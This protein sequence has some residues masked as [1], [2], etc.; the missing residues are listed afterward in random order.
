MAKNRRM[1]VLEEV[2]F[3]AENLGQHGGEARGLAHI[4]HGLE[5]VVA[6]DAD[7]AGKG[8]AVGD[9]LEAGH[10]FVAL[11]H[12]ALSGI[13]FVFEALDAARAV[14]HDAV[15]VPGQPGAGCICGPRTEIRGGSRDRRP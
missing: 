13:D 15:E 3:R 2:D 6:H 11:D 10:G 5:N 8:D 4:G 14:A 7:H 9:V 12:E 1:D